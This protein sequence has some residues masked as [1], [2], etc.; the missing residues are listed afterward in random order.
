M[1]FKLQQL[2]HIAIRVRDLEKSVQW[3]TD[4]LGL[5]KVHPKEWG[6]FPIMMLA[7]NSGVALFPSKTTQPKKLPADDFL[8]PFHFAFRINLDDSEKVKVHLHNI[9]IDFEFQDLI[10]FH[11]IFI[12]DPDD[13]QI[14]I[15]CQVKKF[16][17][18]F[19]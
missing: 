15:T 6:A 19:Q 17:P 13:Y 11:S 1:N 18:F 9:G 8:T 4:V 12:S 16:K 7:G 14:E 5:K 3:Y 2:D 10:H